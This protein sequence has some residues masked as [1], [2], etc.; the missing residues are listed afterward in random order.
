M[1][2]T[3]IGIFLCLFFVAASYFYIFSNN[4]KVG[5]AELEEGQPIEI[6]LVP[7]QISELG[8]LGNIIFELNCQSC[9]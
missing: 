4:E 7:D 1:N 3:N 5:S 2:K 6:V 9:H 8:L